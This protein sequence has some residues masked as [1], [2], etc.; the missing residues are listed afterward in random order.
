[1]KIRPSTTVGC[2]YAEDVDGSPNAH[3]SSSLA[4]A[5]GANPWRRNSSVAP[6]SLGPTPPAD[7]A[8][9]YR[10]F[11]VMSGLHPFQEGADSCV[12]G[13]WVRHTFDMVSAP[14]L[15]VEPNLLP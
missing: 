6:D 7:F 2:P 4:T 15:S 10:L 8:G 5:A 14:P 3:F 12:T 1:M 9:W 13:G 11:F